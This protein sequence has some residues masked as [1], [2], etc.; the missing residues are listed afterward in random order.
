MAFERSVDVLLRL[1]AQSQKADVAVLS[2]GEHLQR[3]FATW[4]SLPLQIE[5]PEQE[6]FLGWRQAGATTDVSATSPLVDALK[7]LLVLNHQ[8]NRLHQLLAEAVR[9]QW[10]LADSKIADRTAGLIVSGYAVPLDVQ[11]HVHKVLASIEDA[12]TASQRIAK[13]NSELEDRERISEA[14]M[15]LQHKHAFTEEEAY[16][17]LK[18]ASRR[19]RRPIAEIAAELSRAEGSQS[20]RIA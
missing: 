18:Q 13:L 12:K 6:L 7:L 10:K 3:S 19:S 20:R 8:E 14:K 16:V 1:I 4:I 9:L 15:A 11:Q 17:Y 2:N 5:L